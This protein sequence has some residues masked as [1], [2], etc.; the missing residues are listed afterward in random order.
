VIDSLQLQ[1]TVTEPPR[2]D[3]ADQQPQPAAVPP[4]EGQ[5]PVQRIPIVVGREQINAS[6]RIRILEFPE[7]RQNSPKAAK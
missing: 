7:S 5:T 1:N 2:R 6:L 3:S 4:Q